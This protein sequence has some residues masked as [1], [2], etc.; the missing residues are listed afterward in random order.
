MDGKLKT[1]VKNDLEFNRLFTLLEDDFW[2]F[3][4]GTRGL[5]G[6]NN[7]DRGNY[8]TWKR[9][10]RTKSKESDWKEMLEFWNDSQSEMLRVVGFV[11]SE[12]RMAFLKKVEEFRETHNLTNDWFPP[13]ATL[14]ITGFFMPPIYNL[15]FE[16]KNNETVSL[17]INSS[18]K[19]SDI[20]EAWAS[21]KELQK[22][23]RI[24]KSKNITPTTGKRL[25]EYI[26][27]LNEKESKFEEDVTDN[28]S[29]KLHDIDWVVRAEIS[30]TDT[31][32]DDRKAVN[33]IRKYKSRLKKS[34]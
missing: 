14:V 3:I 25:Y 26:N 24:Y 22:E 4:N 15:S 34:R 5:L 31:E 18:T 11:N 10:F 33:R 7:L 19:L 8:I 32:E 21:I 20:K 27:Y 1:I 9:F 13:L 16:K 30:K 2:K 6:L 23:L 29:Y 12:K 28:S 17:E